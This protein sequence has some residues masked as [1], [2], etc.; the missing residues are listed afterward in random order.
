MADAIS[1]SPSA[2]RSSSGAS[3][4]FRREFAGRTESELL[5]YHDSSEV[6]FYCQTSNYAGDFNSFHPTGCFVARWQNLHHLPTTSKAKV[7]CYALLNSDTSVEPSTLGNS[8]GLRRPLQM[9]IHGTNVNSQNSK[10]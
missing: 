8:H 7:V 4:P 5:T 9:P 1:R 2:S 3:F 6:R 10:Q